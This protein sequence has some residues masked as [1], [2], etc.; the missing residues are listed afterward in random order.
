MLNICEVVRNGTHEVVAV[1]TS[2]F[3]QFHGWYFEQSKFACT[4]PGPLPEW[5]FNVHSV[6]TDLI[7]FFLCGRVS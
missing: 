6:L 5:F 1:G 7:L 3:N 4:F 2:C